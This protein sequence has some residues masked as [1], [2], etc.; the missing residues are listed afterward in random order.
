VKILMPVVGFAPVG[1]LEIYCRDVAKGLVEMGHDVTVW[2]VLDR[3]EPLDGAG[4]QELLPASRLGASIHYRALRLRL[5]R[6]IATRPAD[7]DLVLCMHPR[8]APGVFRGLGTSGPPYWI[9]TFGTDVWGKWTRP[10]QEAMA[11]AQ[12]V[13]TISR[14]TA[15][16]IRDRLPDADVPIVFPTVDTSRFSLS[17]IPP[18]GWRDPV[19]LTVSRIDLDDAYKGHDK[20]IESIPLIEDRLGRR[21]TYRIVGGG[22]GVQ[23]LSTI[24]RALGVED[25]V[26]F[27]G[28]LDDS[29]LAR[30]YREC[31]LFVMPSRTDP[32]PGGSMRGEGFGIV[33]IEAQATGRPVVVSTHAAASET[34]DEGKTGW[35]VDPLSPAAIADACGKILSL[36]DRGRSMGNAGRAFVTREFGLDLFA[37]HLSSLFEGR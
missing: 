29:T 25:R 15:E 2:S 9:W 16:R 4:V 35:S 34:I 6:R 32:A 7:T 3:A 5:S 31:D 27:L 28:R 22:N 13:A 30:E 11:R 37:R 8:L 20:V 10:L 12:K 1:G 33:Y 23:R 21:V 36:P 18:D 19:L 17:T 26:S 24:A 14:F